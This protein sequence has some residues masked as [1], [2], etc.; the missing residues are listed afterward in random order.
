MAPTSQRAAGL[1]YYKASTRP[2]PTWSIEASRATTR[3]GSSRTIAPTIER[4]IRK[5]VYRTPSL[6]TIWFGA[7]DAALTTGYNSA[8][9]VSIED[10][11]ENLKKIVSDFWTA[12]P[13]ADILLITPPHVNDAAR[14]K[15]A[16]AQN[17]SIDRTNAMTKK[18]AQACVETGASIGVPVLDLNSYFNAMN[19][20]TRDALLIS[21]GLHFNSSGNELVYEQLT[22][23]IAD[24]FPS[25]ATKLKV[26][27]FP[28]YSTYAASDPW[29]SEDDEFLAIEQALV[30]TKTMTVARNIY[31]ALLCTSMSTLKPKADASP[32]PNSDPSSET[33]AGFLYPVEPAG[34]NH[35]TIPACARKADASG[36]PS[37]GSSP[38]WY[39]SAAGLGTSRAPRLARGVRGRLCGRGAHEEAPPPSSRGGAQAVQASETF[40]P[41]MFMAPGIVGS[42]PIPTNNWWGNMIAATQEAGVQPIWAN[43]YS[44]QPM[45]TSAPYGL[46]I[47]YPY[48][49]RVFG[50]GRSGNGIAE[51]FYRHGHVPDFTFSAMEFTTPPVFEVFDWDDLSV[52]VRFKSQA[53]PSDEN[54][55][56]AT[57]VSGMAFVT[58]KY[59]SLTPRID[60][61]YA[62]L[63]VNGQSTASGFTATDSR[64]VLT[65]NNGQTW[66]LYFSSE[67]TLQLGGFSTFVSSSSFS[68]TIRVAMVPNPDKRS[69][70]DETAGCILEGGNVEA[71]DVNTYAYVW[72]S[73][74]SCTEP[75]GLLHYAQIHHVDTLDRST[76]VEVEGVVA[77]STTR[78]PMQ[79]L[80]TTTASPMWRFMDTTDI[81]ISF[82]PSRAP[83]PSDVEQYRIKETLIK[84]IGSTWKIHVS[85]SYYFNGK[86]A[87]KYASLCLMAADPSVVGTGFDSKN[88]LHRCLTKLKALLAPFLTNSWKYTL[89]Y[90][91]VYR[92]ILSSQGFALNDVNADFGNTM[93]NDHHYHYGY[94]IVT[95]AIVNKLDPTW[96][97]IAELNRMTSFLVRDVAN[98]SWD[99]PYFTKFRS[100]DWFRG[101]SYSHGVLSFADGKDQKSS[102]EDMNFHYGV[103]L[104]GQVTGD[105]E[106]ATIGRLMTRIV[107]SLRCSDPTKSREFC[108]ITK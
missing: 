34:G 14:A 61:V 97:G 12:A 75:S 22:E 29:T 106:L 101:H 99:D 36:W 50:G 23:K 33:T 66:A 47:S 69:V 71:Q 16:A 74:G 65:L 91:T 79:A 54:S 93:Y 68:G 18:Y 42:R 83:S 105:E 76:A 1:H 104:F 70:F 7:N 9:H 78:G 11:K 67:V 32:L 60:T 107:R 64:F 43:P 8:Q 6:I 27:Q 20:T 73:S 35:A 96:S 103:A 39:P 88:L 10:Y 87:Q 28:G 72:K 3:N 45:L 24:V 57:L 98:P 15:L 89:K 108:S 59:A 81:P 49:T 52:Q 17:G 38:L 53:G 26:S 2:L 46:T 41:P 80:I 4:E 19:E 95:A 44:L 5:G 31:T 58:A 84:D 82:Y 21:D 77:Y 56:E 100:F 102:S 40:L 37:R 13:T 48:P 55:F 25:L 94:W 63:T 92:G 30:Q 85:G 51:K 90:D 62:I 86:A